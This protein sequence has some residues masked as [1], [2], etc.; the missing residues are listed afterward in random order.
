[1]PISGFANLLVPAAGRDE[2]EEAVAAAALRG[3]KRFHR[4]LALSYAPTWAQ[5]A[6][7]AVGSTDFRGARSES[8]RL[9]PNW[10]QSWNLR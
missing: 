9:N 1:M 7:F 4:Q 8:A 6:A 2:E 5:F 10:P 3:I